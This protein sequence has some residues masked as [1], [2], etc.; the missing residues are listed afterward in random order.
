MN[1]RFTTKRTTKWDLFHMW[2]WEN[3]WRGNIWP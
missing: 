3:M 1:I 2:Q